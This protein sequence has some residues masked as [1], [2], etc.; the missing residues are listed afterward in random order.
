MIDIRY[1]GKDVIFVIRE[2]IENS[3][4]DTFLKS[5]KKNVGN[6]TYDKDSKEWRVKNG[7]DNLLELANAVGV[8]DIFRASDIREYAR[9]PGRYIHS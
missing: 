3:K 8:I 6:V 5:L 7:K 4:F 1:E 2:F 9:S